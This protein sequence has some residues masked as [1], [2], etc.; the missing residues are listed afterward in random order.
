[1]KGCAFFSKINAPPVP[2]TNIAF[3]YRAESGGSK[4]EKSWDQTRKLIENWRVTLKVWL[5]KQSIEK[6]NKHMLIECKHE[7]GSHI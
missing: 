4:M 7:L 5:W 6:C 3:I 1:M 2:V